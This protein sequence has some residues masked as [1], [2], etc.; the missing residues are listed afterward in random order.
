MIEGIREITASDFNKENVVLL[1]GDGLR[2]FI[3]EGLAAIAEQERQKRIWEA[4]KL[5]CGH[6]PR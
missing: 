1:D 5:A 4:T 3:Q 6:A 2:K